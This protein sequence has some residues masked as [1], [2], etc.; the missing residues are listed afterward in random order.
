MEALWLLGADGWPKDVISYNAAINACE[1]PPTR[2]L[3]GSVGGFGGF[4]GVVVG[5]IFGS[6]ASV[7]VVDSHRMVE[8]RVKEFDQRD[9]HGVV[10]VYSTAAR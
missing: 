6:F 3:V 5:C 9:R 4:V 2:W 8:V 7:E 10:R 1:A